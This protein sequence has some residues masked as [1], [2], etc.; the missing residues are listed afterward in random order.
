MTSLAM[1]A[2]GKVE[3]PLTQLGS[4][5]RQPDEGAPAAWLVFEPEMTEGLKERPAGR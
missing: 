2:I 5:P 3:S 1:K 4:A